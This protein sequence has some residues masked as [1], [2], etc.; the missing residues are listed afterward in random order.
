MGAATNVRQRN[1]FRVKSIG[2]SLVVILAVSA[3]YLA[4][5]LSASGGP[6][7][8]ALAAVVLVIVIE[9]VLQAVLAIGAGGA[10]AAGDWLGS[11]SQQAAALAAPSAAW[12][13]GGDRYVLGTTAPRASG[14]QWSIWPQQ[15][16]AMGREATS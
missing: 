8:L 16:C 6:A 15:S 14:G 9:A 5:L 3:Y 10:P 11:L 13:R 12:L 7:Q 1:I 4:S 2:V